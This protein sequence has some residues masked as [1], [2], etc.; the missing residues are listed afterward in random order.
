MGINKQNIEKVTTKLI[1]AIEKSGKLPW[2]RPW[3]SV[4][5]QM[6]LVHQK[7]YRGFN[8]WMTGVQGFASP[9]WLT[10]KQAK[11]LGGNVKQGSKGTEIIF[12]QINKKK[13]EKNGEEVEKTFFM[14]KTYHIFNIEQIDGIK[15]LDALIAKAN[16][17]SELKEIEAIPMAEMV[18]DNY[19]KS[20]SEK[21]LR[22]GGDRAFY[23]PAFDYVQMPLRASFKSSEGFYST[24]F[25]EFAHSTGHGSRLKRDLS[26]YFGN[27]KYSY[28]EL[29]AEMTSAILRA[30]CGFDNDAQDANTAAYVQSWLTKL[31]ES[32]E[33]IFK[34]SK[35]A[36]KAAN[37]IYSFS[38][39]DK[40]IHVE[41]EAE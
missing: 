14:L 34:A 10:F 27:E 8:A 31:K 17:S 39:K 12:W 29:V 25:H 28:E 11:S 7:P 36:E 35:D 19:V 1:D 30:E 6:N 41:Q 20:I 13:E 40:T 5:G 26:G 15:N 9:Y 24:L 21:F 23:A 16:G 33:W 22:Y 4:G 3:R 2:D 18:A 32:P 37:L 38:K